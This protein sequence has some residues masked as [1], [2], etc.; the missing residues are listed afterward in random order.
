[1]SHFRCTY[2]LIVLASFSAVSALQAQQAAVPADHADKM[3]ASTALFKST[4]RAFFKAQC[5]DCHGGEKTKSGFDMSSREKMLEGGDRGEA[6]VPGNAKE[7]RLYKLVARTEEPYMPAKKPVDAATLEALAKWID[8]GAAYDAPISEVARPTIKAPMVVTEKDRAAWAYKTLAEVPVPRVKDAAW[9]RNEIDDFVLAKLDAAKLAP[10]AD[11]AKLILLRRISFDLTGLPPTIA[12]QDE[13]LADSR[14]DATGILIDKLLA[15]P[16]YGERWARHWLDV[17]RYAESHG[18][19]HDYY[20]PHAYHYR[21]F[22]IRA[23]NTNMPYDK[24][25]RWQLA[26]DELAPENPDALAATGFLGAGVYPTQITNR[27]A[28]RVRYDAMDDMLSTTGH[29]FLALTVGCARCHDHK[30][31]PIPTKDYYQ[32]LA[33]FATTVRTEVEVD[34]SPPELKAKHTAWKV[35]R[36]S[37]ADTVA[38][39]EREKLPTALAGWLNAGTDK[40]DAIAKLTDAKAA[41]AL[42]RLIE[43]TASWEELGEPQRQALLKWYA[44]MDAGWTAASSKLA[45]HDTTEPKLHKETI[46]ATSEGRKPM[47]HHTADNTIPDFY[48]ATYLLKRGDAD[49]KDGEVQP[50]FLQVLSR[51][52]PVSWQTAKPAGATTSYRRVH[53]AKWLLDV[54]RGAGSLAARVM[55]NRVWH[56]HFGRGLVGTL[57]DF[58]F[59]ADTP[60]HPELL[61]WLARDFVQYGWDIKRLHKQILQSRTYQLGTAVSAE[62]KKIDPDNKLLSHRVKRRLEA[63]AVRDNWLAVSGTLDAKMYGPGAENEAMTRRSIYFRVQRSQLIPSLQIFDWPDTLTSTG[64]RTT[65][66]VAP[67]ALYFLNSPFVGAGATAWTEQLQ[68]IAAKDVNQAITLAYRQAFAR[69]PSAA[70]L[71]QGTAFLRSGDLANTLPKYLR[72]LFSLNEFVYVE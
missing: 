28:E 3:V 69:T 71:T 72:V 40:L 21:D 23:F 46:Q 26:G 33:A 59:Q 64:S 12:E 2:S 66:T 29:A 7:S 30:Y 9:P 27:E 38:K 22:T 60:T 70:E 36:A 6:I 65:T 4:V 48:K 34:L 43:K 15:K 19:E 39:I 10:A 51:T 53:L 14:P 11:A 55:V 58:G 56:Y 62:A 54:E 20:R 57:N 44:P 31:D 8:G 67:Q 32:L 52:T 5:F 37:L 18:F 49:Q 63:E 24:F 41:A 61:D 35:A 68:P 13:F 47:R 42:K 16:T 45:E 1:M 17:A 25:V 50:G